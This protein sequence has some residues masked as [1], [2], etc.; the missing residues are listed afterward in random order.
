MTRIMLIYDA[1][2]KL[3]DLRGRSQNGIADVVFVRPD[4]ASGSKVQRPST[5]RLMVAQP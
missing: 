2:L 5:V 4:L 1:K 3:Y